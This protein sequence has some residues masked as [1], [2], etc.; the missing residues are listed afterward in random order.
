MCAGGLQ[1]APRIEGEVRA[2]QE[3]V[4]HFQ[5]VMKRW[6][7]NLRPLFWILYPRKVS[8]KPRKNPLEFAKNAVPKRKRGESGAR[9]LDIPN[10]KHTLQRCYLSILTYFTQLCACR[11]LKAN[12][13]PTACEATWRIRPAWVLLFLCPVLA[14]R[15]LGPHASGAGA[16]EPLGALLRCSSWQQV[17]PRRRFA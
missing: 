7:G 6:S 16:A 12:T 11:Y 4:T 10:K 17:W 8:V 14:W 9:I 13:R 3:P 15:L 2:V 5:W 1:S